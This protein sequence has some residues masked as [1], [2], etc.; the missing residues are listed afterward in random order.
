MSSNVDQMNVIEIDQTLGP[1]IGL[2]D[3]QTVSVE[4]VHDVPVASTVNVEPF[5]EDD[6]EILELHAGYME[7]QMLNQVRVVAKNQVIT[8]WVHERTAIRLRAVETSPSLPCVRLDSNT[9]VIVAPKER[10]KPSEQRDLN[11][12]ED[13]KTETNS[14]RYL[15]RVVCAED[16]DFELLKAQARKEGVGLSSAVFIHKSSIREEK[17]EFEEHVSTL[18]IYYGKVVTF[19]LKEKGA[20]KKPPVEALSNDKEDGKID[21]KD[22]DSSN[23]PF[24]RCYNVFVRVLLSHSVPP[25]HVAMAGSLRSVLNVST[26]QKIRIVE[27]SYAPLKSS[28]IS[29]RELKLDDENNS[30]KLIKI[31]GAKEKAAKAMSDVFKDWLAQEIDT[32]GSCIL[33][34]NTLFTS[35]ETS[36]A[37]QLLPTSNDP[38]PV[39][40]KWFVVDKKNVV[41]LQI[42]NGAPV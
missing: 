14:I 40:A 25:G 5:T 1:L 21:G 15:G 7:E 27:A 23:S 17:D 6:W 24:T 11:V 19:E 36:Y 9:E 30:E 32:Y 41:K 26:F 12:D 18:P 22:T 3:R 42:A 8:V 10:T 16:M 39:K 4:L 13:D 35:G 33:T 37:I 28:K 31:G 29:I 34:S 20:S 38:I 2:V